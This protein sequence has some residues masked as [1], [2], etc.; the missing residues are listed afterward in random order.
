MRMGNV[1]EPEHVS[2]IADFLGLPAQ[3]LSRG[4]SSYFSE[5]G[6]DPIAR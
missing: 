3:N 4:L 2:M 5:Q 6:A 1:G